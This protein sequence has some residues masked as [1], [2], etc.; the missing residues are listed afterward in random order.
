MK[1][2]NSLAMLPAYPFGLQIDGKEIYYRCSE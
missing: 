1:N 2:S